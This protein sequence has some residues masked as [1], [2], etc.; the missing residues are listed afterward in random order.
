[1]ASRRT[2]LKLASI[3]GL[4]ASACQTLHI[5]PAAP[6][7]PSAPGA[8]G[9][10]LPAY[11]PVQGPSPDLPGTAAGARPAYFKFPTNLV[12]SVPQPPGK[13]GD[14]NTLF[15]VVTG[16]PPTPLEQNAA[17]Q[18]VNKHVNANLKVVF[19]SYADYPARLA[20][21]LAGNDL[22]DMFCISVL[23]SLIQ[24]MPDF[25]E[26][27]CADLTPFLAGDAIKAYPNLANL[28]S[29]AW[30]TAVFN[31]KIL[32]I[33]QV[34]TNTGPDLLGNGKQ[35]A[36]VGA[37]FDSFR[38]VDDFTRIAKQ[39]TDPG[40]HWA[41]GSNI[42]TWVMQVFRTPNDWRE[43]GGKLIKDIE[44]E[45]YKQ[46]VAYLRSLWDAGV[47][48]PDTP[49]ATVNTLAQGFYAGRY[50]FWPNLFLSY[51]GAWD[52]TSAQ[53]PNFDMRALIPF[54]HDGGQGVQF[55]G[56][57][58][59]G[60]TVLKKASDD[61]I[62]ELLGILNYLAAPFGSEESLLVSYG[63]KDTDYTLNEK[64]NPILTPKG[65]TDIVPWAGL[66]RRPPVLFDANSDEAAKRGYADE[67]AALAIGIKSPTVGLYSNTYAQKGSSLNRTF[68]DG[69]NQIL[70]GRDPIS[71]LDDLVQSWRTS[72]G[73]QIRAEYEQALQLAG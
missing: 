10:T 73:D 4:A 14:V 37:K 6:A 8:S 57:G 21:I 17:W 46:A 28:P 52:G 9:L 45:E 43:S 15:Y 33:P 13:G 7:A 60:L 2:F 53:D 5:A 25:M 50:T 29:S 58:S 51:T 49:A 44:T 11:V 70:Y 32:C 30:P 54:G 20:T 64:G 72:G 56:N 36:Q 67:T 55:L 62:K 71:S 47:I 26:R 42:L 1:V 3:A 35:L 61:R 48:W 19:V 69:I 38:S 18:A 63:I 41:I 27:S 31:K 16:T 59:I 22:P 66:V 68:T 39:L 23:G 24:G 40:N 65:Q 34:D 12:T